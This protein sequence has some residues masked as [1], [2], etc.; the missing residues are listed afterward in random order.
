MLVAACRWCG[1]RIAKA[2]SRIA[3]RA[4][5]SALAT[6]C[7][8]SS[9]SAKP[10]ASVTHR[11]MC[12]CASSGWCS[13]AL[14]VTGPVVSARTPNS[15]PSAVVLP[16][17]ARPMQATLSSIGRRR[18]ECAALWPCPRGSA[19]AVRGLRPTERRKAA[20]A[21]IVERVAVMRG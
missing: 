7:R 17:P 1:R 13:S 6:W 19:A 15:A 14:C 2:C 18:A 5:L 3:A 8:A 20:M 16:S 9:S 10:G 12:V 11:L 4:P 21:S